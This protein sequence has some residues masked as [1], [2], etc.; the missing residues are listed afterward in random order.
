MLS[1]NKFVRLIV[2]S[3]KYSFR[4]APLLHLYHSQADSGFLPEGG[5][6]RGRPAMAPILN[7]WEGRGTKKR[8]FT[9]WAPS[10][11]TGRGS[12]CSIRCGRG[13]YPCYP[14]VP[15][16]LLLIQ[17][18]FVR[19]SITCTLVIET[20]NCS[21]CTPRCASRHLVDQLTK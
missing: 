21:R 6:G 19:H 18:H 14:L 17:F 13:K 5:P 4:I 15:P 2:N 9:M 8:H 11:F 3:N 1:S 20:F 7:S 10:P 16:I 12:K